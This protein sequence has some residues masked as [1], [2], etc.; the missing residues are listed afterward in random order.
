MGATEGRML[1][2]V[3]LSGDTRA[4][5]LAHGR[6][7]APRIRH[8]LAVYFHR[9]EHEAG[10][11]PEDVLERVGIAWPALA[12]GH[13][14]YAAGVEGIAEGVGE[15]LARIA[16]LNL[17]YEILYHQFTA[18]AMVD[19]CTSFALLPP[20]TADGHLYMG[21]NWDWIPEVQGAVLRITEP[22]LPEQLCFTEAGIFGG[23][24]G[25]NAAGVGV[26]INGLT[27]TADDWT[28]L[29]APVHVRTWQVLRSR[30]LED[31]AAAVLAEPRSC[32]VHLLVAQAAGAA[33]RGAHG[34]QDADGRDAGELPLDRAWGLETA[35]TA[36]RRLEPEAGVYGHANHFEDEAAI[37]VRQPPSPNRPG[38]VHRAT[39]CRALLS[40][41]SEPWTPAA[42][43]EQLRDH[44]GRPNSVCRHPDPARG[45]DQAYHTVTSVLMDLTAGRMWISDGPPCEAEYQALGLG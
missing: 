38:S 41:G 42:I 20:R 30:T 4:Q 6:L 25:M 11:P 22:G 19:G 12:A 24:I 43:L 27:S 18:K 21:Q 5:G 16:A 34:D 33:S 8:N 1:P 9:F 7:L 28:R 45:P 23:K 32:S 31:A 26:A 39:R 2:V 29:G 37:G 14:A 15:P 44:D 10:L 36:A 35:P 3:E 17:R 13:P 40:A